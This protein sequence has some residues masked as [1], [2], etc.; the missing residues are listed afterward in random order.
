MLISIVGSYRHRESFICLG[1]DRSI[2]SDYSMRSIFSF[3]HHRT[4][5]S[6]KT[7]TSASR[8]ILFHL[9]Y[10]DISNFF[11]FSSKK[12]NMSGAIGAVDV[13]II[14]RRTKHEFLYCGQQIN[15]RSEIGH[16]QSDTQRIFFFNN[17]ITLY[18]KWSVNVLNSKIKL[19]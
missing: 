6:S 10:N 18:F 11:T 19:S 4:Q 7:A 3:K 12:L 2:R 16:E 13:L 8:R 9:Q 1:I 5:C 17:P 14:T 15:H